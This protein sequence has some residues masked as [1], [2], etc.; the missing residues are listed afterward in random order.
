MSLLS[1]RYKRQETLRD[2]RVAGLP[3]AVS[4]SCPNALAYETAVPARW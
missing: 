4:M 1:V 2:V 3:Y